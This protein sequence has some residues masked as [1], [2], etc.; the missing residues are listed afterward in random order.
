MENPFKWLFKKKDVPTR[1][2]RLSPQN[3]PASDCISP[4][5]SNSSSPSPGK[6]MKVPRFLAT[7][8]RPPLF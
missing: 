2:I 4:S 1:E 8:I 5:E 6:K 3:I 7:N